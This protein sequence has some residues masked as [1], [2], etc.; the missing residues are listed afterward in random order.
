MKIWLCVTGN[1]SCYRDQS[2]KLRV[3]DKAGIRLIVGKLYSC[4]AVVFLSGPYHW[5]NPLDSHSLTKRWNRLKK[6]SRVKV[7]HFHWRQCEGKT[8]SCREIC[9]ISTQKALKLSTLFFFPI[10][11][12]RVWTTTETPLTYPPPMNVTCAPASSITQDASDN[13]TTGVF[14]SSEISMTTPQSNTT[15]VPYNS[16]H[17]PQWT[18]SS[19]NTSMNSTAESPPP[20]TTCCK[21][22]FIAISRVGGWK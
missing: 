7:N 15:S 6:H 8:L 16:S 11:D 19:S 1:S 2:W 3:K 10:A 9:H 18:T 4:L 13:S 14:S 12:V 21:K 5:E 22:C 17:T 20:A